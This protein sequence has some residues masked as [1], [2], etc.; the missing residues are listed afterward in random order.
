MD[1]NNGVGWRDKHLGFNAARCW[2]YH[3]AA[4]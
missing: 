1:G 3:I 2:A 4:L